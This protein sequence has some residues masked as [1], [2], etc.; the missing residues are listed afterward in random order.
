MEYN[1]GEFITRN[2]HIIAINFGDHD[3]TTTNGTTY[4]GHMTII[5]AVQIKL[6]HVRMAYIER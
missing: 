2:G 6:N 3:L 1:K 5:I 4:D